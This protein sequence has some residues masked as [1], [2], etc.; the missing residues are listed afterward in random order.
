MPRCRTNEAAL[1]FVSPAATHERVKVTVTYAVVWT[2]RISISCTQTQP[3]T[4][5]DR[6]QN[7]YGMKKNSPVPSP[8]ALGIDQLHHVAEGEGVNGSC[9]LCHS[10]GLDFLAS[11][12]GNATVTLTCRKICSH[13][14]KRHHDPMS[15]GPLL[16][17]YAMPFWEIPLLQCKMLEKNNST[18]VS[19]QIVCPLIAVNRV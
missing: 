11:C 7:K 19:V 13:H 17:M 1:V 9:C 5:S 14:P 3:S 15:A 16:H 6:R 8:Y 2:D 12:L 10:L 4:C 18:C